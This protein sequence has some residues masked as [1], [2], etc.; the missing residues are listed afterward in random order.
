MSEKKRSIRVQVNGAWHDLSVSAGT[1]LLEVLREQLHLTGTKNGCGQGHCGACTVIVD[2]RA[3]RACI[4][5]AQRADGRSVT[6]IE[7]LATAGG[8]LHPLQAAFIAH[9]AV[10]C[11][12]C[13]PGFILAAKALLDTN[14]T[15]GEADIRA[16]LRHNLC[17][18]TGYTKIVQAIQSVVSDEA[19][20]ADSTVSDAGFENLIGGSLQRPD[21]AGKVTGATRFTDDLQPENMLYAAVRRSD[22]P[23]A[24]LLEVDVEEA[25]QMPGVVTV[26]TAADVP[27]EKNHGVLKKDWP[28]LAA[29]K[30]RCVGD[31]VALVAA[32]RLDQAQAAAAAIRIK[33]QVLPVVDQPEQALVPAAPEIHAGGNLLKRVVLDRGNVT[34]IFSNCDTV[35]EGT[36]RTPFGEHAFIEPESSLAVPDPDTGLITVYTGSQ[37]PFADRAQIAASLALPVEQV[38]LVHMPTGG[39]F[40]GKEDIHTQIHAA[41]LAQVTQRPVKLTFSRA[42]SLRVHPKRHPTV[43]SLRTAASREGDILAHQAGIL[44][45]TGAYASLGAAVMTR[46]ANVSTGPYEIPNVHIECDTV[47]TNN[48]PAGSFRGFGATQAHF[49]VESHLDA[50][51]RELGLSPFEFRRRNAL[52]VGSHTNTGQLLTESVGLLECIDRVER[53][54]AGYV[55]RENLSPPSLP[56]HV[57]RGWGMACGYKNVGRGSGIPDSAWGAV[58]ATPE[59]GLI[60]RAG[61]ADVGQGLRVILTQIAAQELGVAPAQ[62]ELI[63]GDTALTKD[64]GPTNASRQTVVTGNAVR[65]A[66][67]ALR[68]SLARTAAELLDAAPDSLVFSAGKVSRE[69]GGQGLPLA[70]VVAQA[71]REGRQTIAETVFTPPVFVAPDQPG[72]SHFAYGYACQAAQVEVNRR[73]GSVRV[74]RVVAATDVG[75]IINRSALEGQVE[76]AVMMGIGYALTERFEVQAGRVQ[77]DSLRRLK[78]PGIDW[79]TQIDTIFVEHPTAAGPYGAKGAGEVAGIP[80][81][82]AITNAIFAATGIRVTTLPVDPGALKGK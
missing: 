5:K 42:E 21:A 4:Y 24:L 36:Y 82:P 76:G 31:A 12:F 32:E 1:S 46:S 68:D 53:A 78:V 81:A 49:A 51:A 22:H 7:G 19:G 79:M 63:L 64:G 74:L 75:R 59:G 13:S 47:Y 8:S 25:R 6:T 33:Y 56:D 40:G 45:D 30:V 37:D 2:G 3:E 28:V 14:P 73:S 65:H 26:L 72:D 58:E 71:R 52:R 27:G 61:A 77:T 39:A 18:C 54:M 34:D 55:E 17:R 15:P 38:R 20:E 66:A 35:L 67:L 48:P 57:Q 69:G 60:V 80:T 16:A 41:L 62:V 43:I 29:D 10:Q 44:G 70:Q 9:G 11:G 50:I 23:H